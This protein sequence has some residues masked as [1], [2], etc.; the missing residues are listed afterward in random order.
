MCC[1]GNLWNWNA[2]GASS[3]VYICFYDCSQGSIER[4]LVL[5]SKAYICSNNMSWYLHRIAVTHNVVSGIANEL[6]SFLFREHSMSWFVEQNVIDSSLC[7]TSISNK[8]KFIWI[9][10]QQVVHWLAWHSLCERFNKI[11]HTRL[12]DLKIRWTA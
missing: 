8:T 3:G 10:M 7:C 9:W 4:Y 12:T 1:V 2:V 5:W 6:F 11:T